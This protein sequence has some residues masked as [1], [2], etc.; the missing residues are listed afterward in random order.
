MLEDETLWPPIELL[1]DANLDARSEFKAPHILTKAAG[2]EALRAQRHVDQLWWDIQHLLLR[3]R[4]KL[5][6]VNV[7]NHSARNMLMKHWSIICPFSAS[8]QLRL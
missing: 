7:A 8:T 5:Q 6:E 3:L 2:W 1:E 4:L